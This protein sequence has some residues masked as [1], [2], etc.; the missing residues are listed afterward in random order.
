[1]T[2]TSTSTTDAN[3]SGNGN[4]ITIELTED[5][6][7]LGV[8]TNF[9]FDRKSNLLILS[10][11]HKD[12]KKT[13]I[14]PVFQ[15]D[16]IKTTQKFKGHMTSKGVNE[17]HAN[18]L[19]D[20]VDNNY[21]R[22]LDIN[23]NGNTNEG[24]EEQQRRK[25]EVFI[26]KYTCNGTLGLYESIVI[27]GQSSFLHLVDHKLQ[28]TPTIESA[29]KIFYPSDTTDTQ[30]PLPYIFNSTE[31]LLE[32]LDLASKETFE[33]LHCM[34]ETVYKKYVNAEEYYLVI[35]AADTIY[36][37]FQ[38]RFG[39]THYNIFVGDNGSGKNSALLVYRYLGYRVFYVTAASAANYYTFLGETEEGQGTTAEDEADDIGY[40][41]D[42]QKI[43]KTGYCS[44]GFVP[45]VDLLNGGGRRQD[46]WLTFCHKW[47][48]MEALP[49]QKKIKGILD[50][51]LVYN[52]V[53]G[54]V[55]YN[56]KD[57]I[58]YAGD[59]K[60][61]PLYDE[62][63]HIRKLLF[64]FRMIHYSD[65]IPDIKLNIVHRSAEL[66]KPLLRLFSYQNNSPTALERIR[67]ALS[68]FIERRNDLKRNSIESKLRDAIN[69]LA[70]ERKNSPELE[71]YKDLQ[72]YS[73]YNEEIWAEVRS[74]TNGSDVQFKPASFYT[75][76]YGPLSHKFITGL[77]RSKFNAKP[78]KIGSGNETKRGLK[79]SKDVLDKLGAYYYDVP[80]EIKI[81]PSETESRSS[82]NSNHNNDSHDSTSQDSGP[83]SIQNPNSI[84]TATDATDATHY[85]E[86]KGENED[87]PRD[88]NPSNN[89]NISIE[90]P[91]SSK[92]YNIQ[93]NQHV[94]D[95]Q[96]TASVKPLSLHRSVASVASVADIKDHDVTTAEDE[97]A[98]VKLRNK[99]KEV[100]LPAIPCIFCSYMDPVE[101]DLVNHYLERH[102]PE[103][104]KLPIGKGSMEYRAE[105]AVNLAKQK[106]MEAYEE[107][108]L[109]D[110]DD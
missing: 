42:K 64:A 99:I 94:I 108:E 45:K 22:I 39:T 70:E 86:G 98:A 103:L 109:R 49:D 15:H 107:E 75:V 79:F 52:F 28:Y 71:K 61:K 82:S 4:L 89:E 35:L 91:D 6:K 31:E 16:W 34:V 83:K 25:P 56:I 100:G 1:M 12:K 60:L 74:V 7:Q 30:N 104:F 44:G 14:S 9:I 40:D 110:G 69:N 27:A 21:E 105:Y 37:Y 95:S 53:A 68:K 72:Q 63:V 80:D 92:H 13:I 33:T 101:F 29:N 46:S 78:F 51:S 2:N 48:S 17:E 5:L 8:I 62:L 65:V 57:I 102:K 67:L 77:Y 11:N 47:A 88:Q 81:N 50:R 36:S 97:A 85:K 93:P 59:P 20:I 32:Y 24:D 55:Q 26:R 41:R 10:L 84:Q 38:D 96:K 23:D 106:L 54:D 76:D 18:M 43:F 3:R 90:S 66:T 19:C 87:I 73:F 58:R